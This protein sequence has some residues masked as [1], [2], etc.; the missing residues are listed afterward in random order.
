MVGACDAAVTASCI[1]ASGPNSGGRATEVAAS[2]HGCCRIRAGVL[3]VIQL[4]AVEMY[5]T[6]IAA[7]AVLPISASA[8]TPDAAL[9]A[10]LEWAGSFRPATEVQVSGSQTP[11]RSIGQ[12]AAWHPIST[13]RQISAAV[14]TSFGASYRFVGSEASSGVK[15]K[16]VWRI[17]GPGL[18]DPR[19][20]RQVKHI[21]FDRHCS[22][23]GAPC[24]AGWKLE[25][26]WELVP[27]VWS[28]EIQVGGKPVLRQEFDLT[29]SILVNAPAAVAT[30]AGE[31]YR[32]PG[33]AKPPDS[34]A[35]ALLQETTVCPPRNTVPPE[36]PAAARALGPVGEVKVALH[37][38]DAGV[39]ERIDVRSSPHPLLTA[40]VEAAVRQW[41]FAPAMRG[42]TP[43]RF[44]ARQTFEF[45]LED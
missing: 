45:K 18:S 12:D 31:P 17:P 26:P 44:V 11:P 30:R 7:L 43:V 13:G 20:G 38:S 27:G 6:L 8:S 14:G 16:A 2:V 39:L 42:D 1:S 9:T 23:A 15:Y 37:I 19:S 33:K 40:A 4:G 25:H 36:Y 41:E 21:E 28:L 3:L 29:V 35:T 34:S 10:E 5:K 22:G 24:S 32:C